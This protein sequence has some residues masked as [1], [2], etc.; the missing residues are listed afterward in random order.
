[1]NHSIYLQRC[2]DLALL[3]QGETSPNPL[4]GAV[5][6]HNGIIIGE[7]YHQKAG[8]PHA[9]VMAIASVENTALLP[10]A[11]LYCNLEP[12]AH[13]GKT[14]PCA[15]HIVQ[16][17]IARVVIGALD[18]N[19]K[20]AGKGVAHM[21]SNGI[22]VIVHEDPT[23]FLA[24]NKVFYTNQNLGRPYFHLKWA[25][26]Q[27]GFIDK[28]APRTQAAKISGP[29]AGALT[30]HLRAIYDGI[31]ISS[32]TAALDQPKLTCRL[33]H[34]ASPR[35]IILQSKAHP[36]KTDWINSLSTKPVVIS[37]GFNQ[38]WN[39][40]HLSI[41]PKNTAE[42]TRALLA[43]GICSVLV[44]GG[45]KVHQHFLDTN[46]AD[47]IHRYTSKHVTLQEGVQAPVIPNRYT[48]A[49]SSTGQTDV[50]EHYVRRSV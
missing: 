13:T 19:P 15:N 35:P 10:E 6:V 7:G 14:P 22:E 25:A 9:E 2:V 17:K 26:S 1:M 39:A 46:T 42:W 41:D 31:L 24:L 48:L 47:E 30:Q 5:V 33:P 3:A 32:K 27:D 8:L 38:D 29:Q 34:K 49:Q 43:L 28:P 11:T 4:V 16:H 12:C 18:T 23:P 45:A 36:I 44:E 21:E 37:Q 40:D 50:I 20:V